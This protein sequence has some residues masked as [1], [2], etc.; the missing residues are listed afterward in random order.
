MDLLVSTTVTQ[1]R[2]GVTKVDRTLNDYISR[3]L[4]KMALENQTTVP[5]PNELNNYPVYPETQEGDNSDYK[6]NPYSP[7]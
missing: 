4:A 1:N 5:V 6:Q 7:A 3:T 2:A